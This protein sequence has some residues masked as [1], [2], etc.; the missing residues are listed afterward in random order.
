MTEWHQLNAATCKNLDDFNW[1][2][3]KAL[4]PVTSY[5]FVPLT[6][7]IEKYCCGLP[8]GLRKYC[9][10]TK[11]T[12][13]T[14]LIEVAN[15][16]N[17][18]KYVLNEVPRATQE[19]AKAWKGKATAEPAKGPAKKW[20]KPFPP[21]KSAEQR[22][23]LRSENKCFICEQRGHFASSCPQK[24]R[25]ADSEDKEDKKGKRSMAGLVPDMVGDRPNSDASELCRAW[26]KVRDQTMLIF[27]DPGAKAN[28]ISPKLASKLGIRSE[29]MGYTAKAGLACLGHTEAV[30]PIIGKLRL[31]IQSYVDVEEFY[32]MPLDR[33]DVLLGIPWLFCVQGI[34]DAYNKKITVQS[35]GKTLILDV[36]LKGESIP[37]ISASASTSVMKKHLSACLVF[38]REVSDCHE[39]NLSVLDKESEALSLFL[40]G[41]RLGTSDPKGCF[42]IGLPSGKSL[43][44]L[45]A[46]R[47]VQVQTL[48][49]LS[50]SNGRKVRITWYIMTSP[51]TTEATQQ[52]FERHKYFGL[53]QEQVIFFE[54]GILPCISKQG[55]FI[56]ETSFQVSRAPDGNGGVYAAL[57]VS[58]CLD[59]MATRGIKYVDCFSVDNALVRVADP[60][61]L[62]YV[63]ERGA[64][65]AAKAFPQEKVGVFA[66]RGKGG[67]L[68]VVEYSELDHSLTYAINQETGRLRFNWSNVCLHMFSLE[69][70]NEVT[71]DLERDSMYHIAEKKISSLEGTVDG[72]KLEQ[73]VFDVFPYSS[74][75]ALFEVLR[76][77]EF[78]PVKNASGATADTP[79]TARLLLLNLHTRWVVAAG[80]FVTHSIPLHLTGIEVSPL[81]SYAGENLE[82]RLNHGQQLSG[83]SRKPT[84]H[85]VE[86]ALCFEEFGLSPQIA[87]VVSPA[88]CKIFRVEPTLKAIVKAQAS[89]V[90]DGSPS[91]AFAT[92]PKLNV[93]F[94]VNSVFRVLHINVDGSFEFA[95][96][97]LVSPLIPVPQGMSMLLGVSAAHIFVKFKEGKKVRSYRG[98]FGRALD[99]ESFSE[100]GFDIDVDP[101]YLVMNDDAD[102][103]IIRVMLS[104]Q[105]IA[106]A[107]PDTV[108]FLLPC[109]SRYGENDEN[110]GGLAAFGYPGV[111]SFLRDA[112]KELLLNLNVDKDCSLWAKFGG[113][114][115]SKVS[116]YNAIKRTL[117]GISSGDLCCSPTKFVEI[118]GNCAKVRSL[119]LRGNS[120][121]PLLL[122]VVEGVA[123]YVFRGSDGSD[124][125]AV[126][127][128]TSLDHDGFVH[129]YGEYVLPFIPLEMPG[130]SIAPFREWCTKHNLIWPQIV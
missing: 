49:S 17:A 11:V 1:K 12:T 50:T 104:D 30:S 72:I 94:A 59:D 82:D 95:T 84:A 116:L 42:S 16:G 119:T 127:L 41:T 15:I 61:F 35:R 107:L 47:I 98:C 53:E 90:H 58:K 109:S 46:E 129:A 88:F 73:F 120:G 96:A 36:N 13:S 60:L 7:R 21:R 54:Q 20:K 87:K 93:A 45:Q 79:D 14:Q 48:A 125:K 76:E 26:G 32:I 121:S 70:L 3:W 100:M 2:F 126:N 64:S 68:A 99:R 40:Q 77:E 114:S 67:P 75:L 43:F 55:K 8:K 105:Q 9:T 6:E 128:A 10:K 29:E 22:Q 56:L 71:E 74:S 39:S 102:L 37:T 122:N 130:R 4:L 86:E 123:C 23:V 118:T 89:G 85:G 5:R 33:C 97:W 106:V 24:K 81:R 92:N 113:V 65:C 110:A 78:A 18:K 117:K 112:E 38:A 124:L 27:F 91:K 111:T 52:F 57:K 63:M 66:R 28:F 25:P 62:G 80:G 34:M 108:T 83:A 44:Q 69:F 51:F 115:S 103:A 31:H 101:L 19:P